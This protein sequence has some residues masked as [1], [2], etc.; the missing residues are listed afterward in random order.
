MVLSLC[1]SRVLR[2]FCSCFLNICLLFPVGFFRFCSMFLFCWLC[3]TVFGVVDYFYWSGLVL[4]LVLCDM[5]VFCLCFM[6]WC[7]WIG[8]L[9][10]W[11]SHLFRSVNFSIFD[12]VMYQFFT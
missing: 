5:L 7:Y 2:L 6:Y 11:F 8:G 3:L 10:L 9:L 1:I 12:G 4:C